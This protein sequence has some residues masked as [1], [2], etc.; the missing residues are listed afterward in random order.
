M[1]LKVYVSGMSGNKEV[2]KRQQRVLMILDSKCIQY[3]TVDITEP[4]KE[5][6]KEL[7][8]NKSTSNGGTV[9]DPEPRH[10][11]PPQIFNDE[12][13]CGDYDAFDM[14]NEIDTLEVFLKL[15]PADTT[16]VSS[17]QIELKQENGDAKEGEK[18]KEEEKEAG[19]DGEE[20]APAEGEAEVEKAEGED[21]ASEDKEKT[22]SAEGEDAEKK[23]EGSKEKQ[24]ATEELTAVLPA[25]A[26]N[27]SSDSASAQLLDT[28]RAA[29]SQ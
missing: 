7:M 3:D 28:E 26:K 11:L 6:E 29:T 13:Y 23:E 1:V 21:E 24:L 18:E 12:E 10:P 2:K 9:S 27:S 17:A 16:A 15:A 22:E 20:K 14:A 25:S 8:Q 19:G 5:S 4:G